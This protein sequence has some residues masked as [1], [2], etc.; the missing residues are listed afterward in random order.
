[1][2]P[3]VRSTLSALATTATFWAAIATSCVPSTAVAA[4]DP[5]VIA[6]VAVDPY[7]DLKKQAKWVG[8]QID[9]PTLDGFLESFIM[10]AT[11]FK[12]LAGLDVNRP[13]G[14]VVTAE[15]P[16]GA[17][18]VRGF[19]PVKD[20]GKLLA[21]LQ[22]VIGPAQEQDGVRLISPPGMP[23][24]VIVE[25]DGWAIVAPQGSPEA[26]AGLEKALDP[27]VK[28]FSLGV[29]VFPARMPEG[30]RKQLE[31]MLQQ[32]AAMQARQQGAPADA[33][34]LPLPAVLTRIQ[35]VETILFGANVDI[36]KERVYLENRA[37]MVAGADAAAMYGDMAKAA[38]TMAT[39]ATADGKPAAVRGHVA[40]AIPESLRED[41]K[42]LPEVIPT[43]GIGMLLQEIVSAMVDTGGLDASLSID[44]TTAGASRGTALPAVTVGMRVKDGAALEAALKKVVTGDGVEARF[45]VGKAG[46]ANL[47]RVEIDR[48]DDSSGGVSLVDVLLGEKLTLT[49]A[50]TPTQAFLLLGDDVEQRAAVVVDGTPAADAKPIAGLDASLAPL[51]RWKAQRMREWGDRAA[52]E[53][54]TAAEEAES[55]RDWLARQDRVVADAA[56]L[57]SALV[58]LLVRPIERGVATQLSAD[59]GAIKVIKMLVG[60]NQPEPRPAD[61]DAPPA[62]VPPVPIPRPVP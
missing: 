12:G 11:Q 15:G 48:A 3:A 34:D 43:E 42:E 37:T 20:L 46:K 9:Q 18:V 2:R 7:A 27:V 29:Q 59:A 52:R 10:M 6:V 21:A 54:K 19:V 35:D 51:L 44:T 8:G 22:G 39:P 30:M 4:D 23:P 24:I 38:S 57:P 47:H 26:P 14:V 50:I 53:G 32:A 25:K 16:A 1:M 56:A 58:Q 40:M 28:A 31:A 5:A 49:L 17:P 45:D 36:D 13:A 62:R 60:L 55:R 33:G 41:A 61:F